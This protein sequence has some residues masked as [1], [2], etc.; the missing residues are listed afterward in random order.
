MAVT[1]ILTSCGVAVYDGQF[2]QVAIQFSARARVAS[3][4]VTFTSSDVGSS[5]AGHAQHVHSDYNPLGHTLSASFQ[6]KSPTLHPRRRRNIKQLLNSLEQG[7]RHAFDD[8]FMPII[9]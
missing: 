6:Y 2:S 3:E 7:G 4:S 1:S 8:V 5:S 9:S